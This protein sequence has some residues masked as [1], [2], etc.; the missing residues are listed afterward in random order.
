MKLCG[1]DLS[2]YSNK[3]KSVGLRNCP[4]YHCAVVLK[5]GLAITM[6]LIRVCH[7]L[8]RKNRGHKYGMKKLRHCYLYV[9]SK[10]F[11]PRNTKLG[12]VI[13]PWLSERAEQS[14]NRAL[15]TAY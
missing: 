15:Y 9:L 3:I 5:I 1:E 7:T 6:I 11:A 14:L 13:K 2:H 12:D 8:W 4:Y 10:A